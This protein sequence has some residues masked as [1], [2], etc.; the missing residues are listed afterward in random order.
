M[1]E[2]ERLT[3][4]PWHVRDAERLF[5]IRTIPDV[6]KWLSKPDAWTHIDEAFEAI[7]RWS[8]VIDERGVLGHWAVV[9]HDRPPVGSVSLHLTPDGAETTIGW[10]LHPDSS[11]H[12][13]AREAAQ[14][15]LHA[16]LRP[17]GVDRIWALMWPQ[18]EASA[19]VALAVGM[20]DLGVVDDPW[21]G[22]PAEPTSR[23]FCSYAEGDVPADLRPVALS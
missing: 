15:L 21:Y 12:G 18:N 13:Y 16:A 1:L 19:K 3:I 23:V 6:A 17:G 8:K 7:G 20:T 9:P 2:T 14:A 10:Y 5:A 22:E 4:R 11:G